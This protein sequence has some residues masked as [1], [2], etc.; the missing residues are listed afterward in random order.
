MPSGTGG[1]ATIIS[2]VARQVEHLLAE[3]FASRGFAT[4]LA[5]LY[6]QALVGQVAL[7]GQWWLD[8]PETGRDEVAASLVNLAWNGLSHLQAE[9]VLHSLPGHPCRS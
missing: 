1:F 6:S 7:V 3:V 4:E 5:G 9:P 8:H 2:D